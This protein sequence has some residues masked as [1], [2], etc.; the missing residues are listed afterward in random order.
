MISK[1][2]IAS[3]REGCKNSF[4]QQATGFWLWLLVKGVKVSFEL[5]ASS[6][7]FGLL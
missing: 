5:R 4:W 1:L 2:E 7:E 3:T 6:C